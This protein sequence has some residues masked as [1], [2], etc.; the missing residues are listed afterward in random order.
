MFK[1]TAAKTTLPTKYFWR[2]RFEP[3]P[4]P[5]EC[6]DEDGDFRFYELRYGAKVYLNFHQKEFFT[7]GKLSSEGTYI[8][9]LKAGI[10]VFY[11]GDGLI[12]QVGSYDRENNRYGK[13]RFYQCWRGKPDLKMIIDHK[14]TYERY[15]LFD[16]RGKLYHQLIWTNTNKPLE[17]QA[18]FTEFY[19][20][21]NIDPWPKEEPQ[22]H[23]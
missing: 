15:W 18:S 10:W 3:P 16:K 19:D 6:D 1:D 7:N 5:W 20:D 12:S 8:N 13:W 17:E 14:R 11:D 21:K 4:F 22:L 23:L 2:E 9:G